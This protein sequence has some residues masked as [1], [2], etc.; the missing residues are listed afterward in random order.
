MVVETPSFPVLSPISL[1][2]GLEQEVLTLGPRVWA[3]VGQGLLPT[4]GSESATQVL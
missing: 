4:A 3:H 1:E 2:G